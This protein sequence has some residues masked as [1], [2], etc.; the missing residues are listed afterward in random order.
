[1]SNT[2]GFLT[3]SV[4]D[5]KQIEWRYNE[6]LCGSTEENYLLDDYFE[7]SLVNRVTGIMSSVTNSSL[8]LPH[9]FFVGIPQ[10]IDITSLTTNDYDLKITF[11]DPCFDVTI[12]INIAA[13]KYLYY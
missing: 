4:S 3:Q 1:M 6:L 11:I 8:N 13:S 10:N 7:F 9:G 5:P 2:T 12:P